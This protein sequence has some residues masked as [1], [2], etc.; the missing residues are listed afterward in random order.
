MLN[1]PKTKL[2]VAPSQ[3]WSCSSDDL[4]R[5]S[6]EEKAVGH[7]DVRTEGDH[8]GGTTIQI[9]MFLLILIFFQSFRHL[10]PEW[11][12]GVHGV[13]ALGIE[14]LKLGGDVGRP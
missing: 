7:R 11:S 12:D 6:W 9:G 2:M 1:D 5:F 3:L 13:T 10:H 4:V 14:A 8:L